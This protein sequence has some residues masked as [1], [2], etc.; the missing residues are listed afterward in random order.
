MRTARHIALYLGM[1]MAIGTAHAASSVGM[2][3]IQKVTEGVYALV[4]PKQQRDAGN[5]ANNA[6]FGV[7]VTN[8]GVV[9]MDPGGSWKGA[10]AIHEAIK[11]ITAEPVKFVVDTGGQDHRWLGNG[12]WAAQGVTIIASDDAVADHKDRESVQLSVL[13]NFLGK[14]LEGTDPVYADVTFDDEYTFELG[15]IEFQIRH[16]GQAH[17]PGDSFV[18]VPSHKT[19]FAGDIVYVERILGVGSQSN[20]K[21]WIHAFDEMAALHPEHVVPGHGHATTLEKAKADTYAYLV[22]LR[23][24]I[25]EHI[26]GGGDMIGSVEVDQSGFAYLELF[27]TLAR[28]NAQQVYSDMEWE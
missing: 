13:D 18:W 8:E 2:L 27:E 12:Y 24:K 26:E 19:V 23:E 22:N 25:A 1:L 16:P 9:L 6:T 4:G 17:T 15:G 11:S 28:R 3:E 7:V 5:L 20:A 10:Q 14:Q 21:S